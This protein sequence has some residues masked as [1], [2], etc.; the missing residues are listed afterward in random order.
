MIVIILPYTIKN[1]KMK[2]PFQYELNNEEAHVSKLDE[3][4]SSD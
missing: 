3:E 4:I 2:I 1:T